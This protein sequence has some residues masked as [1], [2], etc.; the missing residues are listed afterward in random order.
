MPLVLAIVFG[1]HQTVDGL[2]V[3]GELGCSAANR[4][5]EMKEAGLH[6]LEQRKPGHAP[7]VSARLHRYVYINDQGDEYLPSLSG[8]KMDVLVVVLLD[9]SKHAIRVGF[10]GISQDPVAIP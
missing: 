2:T 6:A 4:C 9:G 3:G 10:P 1:G 5:E 7:V 8:G